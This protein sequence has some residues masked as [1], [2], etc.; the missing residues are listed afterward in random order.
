MGKGTLNNKV[1][2]LYSG[3]LDS[4][5]VLAQALAKQDEVLA[6]SIDYKQSNA[7]ELV[8]AKALADNWGFNHEILPMEIKH[9]NAKIEVPARN[10]MFLS[11]ALELALTVGADSVA[12]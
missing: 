8:K 6:L 4:T 7:E 12:Y 9:T 2:I 3:G 11:R 1:V 5:V 10:T